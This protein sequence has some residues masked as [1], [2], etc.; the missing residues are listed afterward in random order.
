MISIIVP[1]YN[2]EAFLL[3]CLES[4]SSQTFRDFEAIL[5]DDTTIRAD[6]LDDMIRDVNST[7][8]SPQEIL[9]SHCYY[10]DGESRQLSI[11]A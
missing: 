1:V 2:V 6:A 4:I 3:E 5:V 8:L 11:C 9:S 10:Y 7:I